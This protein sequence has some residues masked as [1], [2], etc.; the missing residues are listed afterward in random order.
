LVL[1]SNL[2]QFFCSCRN[3]TL[4][5]LGRIK[6]VY[7]IMYS[8]QQEKIQ[9]PTLSPVKLKYELTITPSIQ[10]RNLYLK[11]FILFS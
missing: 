8:F 6:T 1:I 10:L 9:L 7:P 11:I 4:Q 3:F 2:N 5:T